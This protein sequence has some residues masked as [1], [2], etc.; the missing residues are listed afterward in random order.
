MNIDMAIGFMGEMFA[1]GLSVATP[2]LMASLLT[3][4]LISIFQVVTQI[5]EM[6]LT[7]VPKIFVSCI[8]LYFLGHWMLNAL[9]SFTKHIISQAA[10][11]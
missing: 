4:V 1:T 3:G 7:F 6:T 2:L 5:Q 9:I 10:G 11:F 8:V